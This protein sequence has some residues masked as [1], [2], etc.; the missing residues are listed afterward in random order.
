M[1]LLPKEVIKG[2]KPVIKKLLVA[3]VYANQ[4]IC[5]QQACEQT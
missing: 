4:N 3:L 2:K 5:L 1:K